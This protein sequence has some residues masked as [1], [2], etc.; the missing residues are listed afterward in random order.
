MTQTGVVIDHDTVARGLS[1]YPW[2]LRLLP[3]SLLIK[4]AFTQQPVVTKTEKEKFS[5]YASERIKECEV[6]PKNAGVMV[7]GGEVVLDHA[8]D[9]QKCSEDSLRQQITNQPLLADGT[10]ITIKTDAVKPERSDADVSGLLAEAKQVAGR[11]V[12][13]GFSCR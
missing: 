10:T 2:Y 3:G 5:L 9:G 7:S 4:G 6:A 11:N 8:K 13:R 12:F 1:E